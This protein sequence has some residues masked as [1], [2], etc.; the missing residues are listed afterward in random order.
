MTRA[1][2]RRGMTGT[3]RRCDWHETHQG[4][5]RG[6]TERP[7]LLRRNREFESASLQR[8]VC[9]L[10]VSREAPAG[11]G[12]LLTTDGA[13]AVEFGNSLGTNRLQSRAR[14]AVTSKRINAIDPPVLAVIALGGLIYAFSSMCPSASR[15]SQRLN[16][17]AIS[18]CQCGALGRLG[19]FSW[20]ASWA[21]CS[22]AYSSALSRGYR[23]KARC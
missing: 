19:R 7:L 12:S 10:S 9:K 23:S 5:Q 16:Y 15:L 8:G 11:Q 3:E 4:G 21:T 14:R 20:P 13:V 22:S 1:G 2:V 6:T 17:G 18:V